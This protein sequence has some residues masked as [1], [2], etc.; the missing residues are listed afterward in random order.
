MLT[1]VSFNHTFQD[2]SKLKSLCED[3]NS[4]TLITTA[5]TNIMP[6][7][8]LSYI[9]CDQKVICH[10]SHYRLPGLPDSPGNPSKP[11]KPGKPESPFGP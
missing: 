8:V 7:T 10:D 5:K 9:E 1:G 6:Y 3:S 11:G 2:I 4:V